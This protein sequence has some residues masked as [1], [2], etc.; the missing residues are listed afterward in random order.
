MNNRLTLNLGLRYEY[1]PWLSGYRGQ[2]G[3][4]DSGSARP[5]IV[6]GE[7]TD[8]DLDAQFAGPSAYALFQQPDPDQQPGRAAR[9]RSPAPIGRSSARASASRGGRSATRPCSAAATGSS[10]NRRAPPIASTTT[11]CRSASIRRPSTTRRRRCGRWPTSSWARALDDLGRADHR[12]ERRSSRRWAATTTSASACSSRWRRSPSSSST[13]SA[14]SAASSTARPTSTSPSRPP[15]GIQARRPFPTVRQHLLLRR[16]MLERPT[17]RCRPRS[18]SAR[19]HGLFY[20]ASYTWSKSMSTQN[21]TAVGG[22][23][24]AREGALRLRRAAQPRDQ[25][26]LGAALRPRPAVPRPTRTP[27]STASW[28]AGRCRAST[29]GAAAGRSRPRSR[30]I[31]PTPASA[32]S[33]RTASGPASSTTRRWK[34]VRQDGVRAAR[35]VHLRRLRRQHP[36]RGQLQDARLLAVQAVP[37]RHAPSAVPGRS[38]Q[39]DQHA[40][41][42]RAEHGHRHRRRRAASP[43]RSS[44]PRQ[45][46]FALKY[47]F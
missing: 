21:I 25:R 37:D 41:L 23:T 43:A 42:Q 4:F 33:G 1:S 46:Q 29:S 12:R 17:T 9:C 20:L 35:A 39:P 18:S 26:R 45:M 47:D 19:T 6:A 15:G 32:A 3:T 30:A 7:G 38:V 27:W 10:T 36:A 8:P 16:H 22:N 31:A 13:T 14:T 11:W 44:T 28:A 5:I 24:G 34:L 40:E 2:V